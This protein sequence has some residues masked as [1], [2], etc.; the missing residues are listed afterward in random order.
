MLTVKMYKNFTLASDKYIKFLLKMG[1]L[2][3]TK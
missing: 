3:L 2:L 1:S